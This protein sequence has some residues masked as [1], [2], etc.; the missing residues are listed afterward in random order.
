MNI[1]ELMAKADFD[2]SPLTVK[3][4]TPEQIKAMVTRIQSNG[5][6]Y[7]IAD[8][9]T[10]CLR[11]AMALH[12]SVNESGTLPADLFDEFKTKIETSITENKSIEA[13]QKVSD[14]YNN[15]QG[16]GQQSGGATHID[17][18]VGLKGLHE[19]REDVVMDARKLSFI[20]PCSKV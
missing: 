14:I 18:A 8:I 3:P 20:S 13:F 6:S 10:A 11:C 17:H 7:A 2:P 15:V 5:I 4:F 19:Q 9:H 12:G 16:A 1:I